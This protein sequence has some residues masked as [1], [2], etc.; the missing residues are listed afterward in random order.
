MG[1]QC[2]LIEKCGFF[3]RYNK[4]SDAVVQGWIKMFCE[5]K[6]KATQCQRKKIKDA[7]GAPPPDNMTPTGTIL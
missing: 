5:S 1:D 3:L 7:T 2:E 6:V 4:R